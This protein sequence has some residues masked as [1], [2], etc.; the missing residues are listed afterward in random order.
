MFREAFWNSCHESNTSN[1]NF[2]SHFIKKDLSSNHY[3]TL[4]STMTRIYAGRSG[5][6]ISAGAIEL[7]LL[8]NMQTSSSTHPASYS[9]FLSGSKVASADS[10]T[11][12]IHL[13][14]SLKI[15]GAL[16]LCNLFP[17]MAHIGT[18]FLYLNLL[19]MYISL[20]RSHPFW[21]Y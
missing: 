13:E 16:P 15:S 3:G 21:S 10:L 17:S 11:T 6:Q 19:P 14:P 4:V 8:Q 2:P 1:P 5:V 7:S 20:N 18:S 12:H 9:G